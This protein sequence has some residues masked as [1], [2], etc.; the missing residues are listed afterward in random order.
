MPWREGWS[1]AEGCIRNQL[2][3]LAR[4]VSPQDLVFVQRCHSPVKSLHLQHFVHP[5]IRCCSRL[6]QA[7]CTIR[8]HFTNIFLRLCLLVPSSH[9]SCLTLINELAKG[10]GFCSKQG[11]GAASPEAKEIHLSL[12]PIS[13][14]CHY[15][16][17]IRGRRPPNRLKS[18]K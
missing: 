16:A 12:L 4:A 18:K 10:S 1:I 17:C 11:D 3:C 2:W 5:H 8:A 14:I 6:R 9:T 15:Q 7:L 13:F